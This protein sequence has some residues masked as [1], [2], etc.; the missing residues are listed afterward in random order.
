MSIS[1]H[2]SE[3][4]ELRIR[5]LPVWLVSFCVW[6]P[7]SVYAAFVIYVWE[8]NS[9]ASVQ[10]TPIL[11]KHLLMYGFSALLTPPVYYL[12]R[13]YPLESG[14]WAKHLLL[15]I[16]GSLLF[17]GI[18][19]VFR[20]WT[21]P[22][23]DASIAVPYSKLMLIWRFFVS[24]TVDFSVFMYWPIVGVAHLVAYRQKYLDRELRTAE[25]QAQLAEAHLRA[26]KMQV[27]PHFLFNTLHS[28]SSLMHTDVNA[29]DKM[30]SRL[31]DLLR[32]GL[33][34]ADT[35][36]CPLR[37]ELRFLDSYL[38]IEQVRFS[39]RLSISMEIDPD[40][41]DA[42]VPYMILQPLVENA[43]RHGVSKLTKKG[44]I[45]IRASRENGWL[46]LAVQ[47]NGPGFSL[48]E[49][50][51][52]GGLGL[53]NTRERME[54]LYGERQRFSVQRFPE[55]G[56]EVCVLVPFAR[57]DKKVPSRAGHRSDEL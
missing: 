40:T 56:V 38:Q 32:L 21:L 9:G 55:G 36:E 46:R 37:Q 50:G 35:Q 28:I 53:S 45:R 19:A 39:D 23:Q 51:E 24:Y 16:A 26:L 8:R 30:L 42:T 15:H 22:I 43:V 20:I 52:G 4:E 25:L 29:A 1:V 48:A 5:W 6:I 14:K 10:F 34:S 57:H 13:R 7:L 12:G 33:E 31:S 2:H 44:K 17:A 3:H 27:H 47:D 11:T 18:H 49:E 41:Y 54:K